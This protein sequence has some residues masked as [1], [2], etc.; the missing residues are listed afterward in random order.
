MSDY[1]LLW[2]IREGQ[3]F[4]AKF[5]AQ[6]VL[7]VSF[8]HLMYLKEALLLV[9]LNVF[10]IDS[11]LYL[12]CDSISVSCEGENDSFYNCVMR[13]HCCFGSS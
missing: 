11:C 2:M 13:F 9:L 8:L 5:A 7:D 12:T 4:F 6:T 1:K 3:C 10:N